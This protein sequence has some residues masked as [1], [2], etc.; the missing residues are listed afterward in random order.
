MS[1][2]RIQRQRTPG[3]RMPE[4]VVYVGR[5]TIWGNPYSTDEFRRQFIEAAKAIGTAPPTDREVRDLA[6]EAFR[7]D[8][9]YGPDSHWWWLGPHTHMIRLKGSLQDG[10]L[11]GHDLACWCPLDQPCHADVLL[12]VANKVEVAR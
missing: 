1:P 10:D 11:T 7:S 3:W 8:L 9:E 6:V 4:G 2:Q 5:P 12:A